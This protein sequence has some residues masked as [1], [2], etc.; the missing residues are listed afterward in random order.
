MRFTTYLTSALAGLFLAVNPPAARAD[1][2][3]EDYYED[4]EEAREDYYED[5]EDYY[6]DLEDEAKD[7]RRY[8][9]SYGG[10]AAEP[11]WSYPQEYYIFGGH[12]SRYY[13]SY[14]DRYYTHRYRYNVAPRYRTYGYQRDP[15]IWR[16]DVY[17]Y[18]RPYSDRYRDGGTY[19]YYD[20]DDGYRDDNR[21]RYQ[22]HYRR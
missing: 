16:Y 8:G 14:P 5:L 15:N 17:G 20:R 11:Y 19:R 18:R 9:Y 6:E 1:D 3:L 12:P 21:G 10:Y 2:D 13:Y 22:R 4:L 7:R